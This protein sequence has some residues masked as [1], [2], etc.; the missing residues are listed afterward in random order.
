[1]STYADKINEIRELVANEPKEWKS[2]A[3]QSVSELIQSAPKESL[4]VFHLEQAKKNLQKD[5]RKNAMN[6]LAAAEVA[7]EQNL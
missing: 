1:M 2:I 7:L 6:S 4:A 3:V 5:D